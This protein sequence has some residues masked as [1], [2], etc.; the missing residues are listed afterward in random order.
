MDFTILVSSLFKSAENLRRPFYSSL[1][2]RYKP[3]RYF[4][5]STR[6]FLKSTRYFLQSTRYFPQS[7]RCQLLLIT[8]S[9]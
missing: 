7:T 2:T 9:L 1:V 5:K 8:Y 4:L 6:Y 3:T